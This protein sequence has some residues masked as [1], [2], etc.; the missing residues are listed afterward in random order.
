[1]KSGIM[2]VHAYLIFAGNAEEA[3]TSLDAWSAAPEHRLYVTSE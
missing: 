3:L 2:K 1:M